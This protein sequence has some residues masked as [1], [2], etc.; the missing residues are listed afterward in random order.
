[1][2]RLPICRAGEPLKIRSRDLEFSF[3]PMRRTDRR[4]GLHSMLYA[5]DPWA[6]ITS[7][8]RDSGKTLELPS[9]ESFVRQAREYFLAADRA[10]AL[11]TKPVLYYYSFLNLS[12]ALALARGRPGIGAKVGHGIAHVA[13]QAG[14]LIQNAT[15]A[16]QRSSTKVSVFDELNRSIS[17][18]PLAVLSIPA[19]DLMAQSILG[20]RMW[21]EAG[22]T[23]RRERFIAIERVV[24]MHDSASQEVWAVIEVPI[25]VMES[26]GR[27]V[28]EVV[29]DGHLSGVFHAV[30]DGKSPNGTP[31]RRFQQTTPIPY[32]GRAADIVAE[33]VS[34]IRPLLWR[35]VTAASPYRRY[36]FYLSPTGEIRL[37]QMVSAYAL[38]FLLG[39]LTRYQPAYLLSAMDGPF[40]GFLREFLAAQPAQVLYGLACEFKRQEVSRAAVV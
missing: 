10:T 29:R 5:T 12:K 35:T 25:E 15:L 34:G 2:P 28:A 39:S 37:P 21:R 26:R 30:A 11:E 40:G 7:S 3:W 20:H 14:E 1:M 8:L 19:A 6:V 32:S 33:L 17:G 38:M 27:G 23:Y 31:V 18:S 9:A 36:F 16:A 24:L 4:W 13:P 22:G